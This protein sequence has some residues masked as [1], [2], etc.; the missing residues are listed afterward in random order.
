[1]RIARRDGVLTGL[2]IKT[3]QGQTMNRDVA[4][5]GVQGMIGTLEIGRHQN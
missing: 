4:F 3:V 5:G 2:V 1:M